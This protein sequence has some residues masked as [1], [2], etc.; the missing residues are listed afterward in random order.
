MNAILENIVQPMV[1]RVGTALAVWLM[2]KGLPSDVVEPLVNYL[3]GFVL[4]L[5]DLGLARLYR[6][7]VVSKTAQA[8]GFGG[9]GLVPQKGPPSVWADLPEDRR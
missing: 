2:A 7:S 9:F 1:R 8:L 6:Q 4:L 5:V 3:A